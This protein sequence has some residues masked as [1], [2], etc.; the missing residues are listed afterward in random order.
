MKTTIEKVKLNGEKLS[1]AFTR[2]HKGT[3]ESGEIVS[4]EGPRPEMI[5]A[6]DELVPYVVSICE[7][8]SDY[9]A[10]MKVTGISIHDT[11]GVMGVVISATKKLNNSRR[12]FVINTPYKLEFDA[13]G[14]ATSMHLSVECVRSI[15]K[16]VMEAEK[17]MK[18][19]R[20]QKD[21]FEEEKELKTRKN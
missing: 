4:E 20:A 7:L 6:F 15:R 17:F 19:S 21:L 12:P 16:V 10:E 5:M 14:Q 8:P 1:I 3:T 11:E 13:N 2:T 18:G 9:I